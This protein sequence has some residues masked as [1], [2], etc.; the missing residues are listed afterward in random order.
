MSEASGITVDVAGFR[1]QVNSFA[2]RYGLDA[3]LVMLDQMR[4]WVGDLAKRTPPKTL[5]Q[6]RAAVARDI[7]KVFE[8]LEVARATQAW[9]AALAK[10]GHTVYRKTARGLMKIDKQQLRE[11]TGQAMSAAHAAA[12][13]RNT[14]RVR[15]N[16]KT[17]QAWGGK[18]LVPRADGLRYI[19]SVQ[20]HVGKLKAGWLP[21]AQR[22]GAKV[23][24]FVRSQPVRMGGATDLMDRDGSGYLEA[25][26]S[27]PWSRKL[28]G[29]LNFTARV[30][31]L[32]LTKHLAKRI[33]R[34]ARDFSTRKAA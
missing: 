11:A 9:A 33:E 17:D 32:D 29:I 18:T 15:V 20:R 31:Q 23:P 10:E 28:D 4:L 22:F 21:A 26:N 6:G 34:L 14:G 30:R 5:A 13:D 8:P 27:V 3:R 16:R 12:R 25:V 2:V 1:Q 7:G 19:R 24:S